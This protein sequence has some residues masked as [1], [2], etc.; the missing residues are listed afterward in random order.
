MILPSTIKTHVVNSLASVCTN[1]ENQG[2]FKCHTLG[3]HEFQTQGQAKRQGESPLLKHQA[4]LLQKTLN[5]HLAA[6]HNRTVASFLLSTVRIHAIGGK[7]PTAFRRQ[8]CCE[9]SNSQWSSRK[10]TKYCIARAHLVF[11]VPFSKMKDLHV[12]HEMELKRIECAQNSDSY[13]TRSST[14][15]Y[16]V[17][18]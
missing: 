2:Y 7:E 14:R 5:S 4:I 12:V 11:L 10:L 17:L 18:S 6:L 1:Q 9:F 16:G 3:Q 13:Y 8:T 15:R